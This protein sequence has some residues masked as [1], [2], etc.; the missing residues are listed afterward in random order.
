MS[1]APKRYFGGS[2]VH[3][4]A[5]RQLEATTW[6]EFVTRYIC[7]PV[8]FH[9]TCAEFLAHPDRDKLK[10]GEYVVAASFPE[11]TTFRKD[12]NADGVNALIMDIDDPTLARQFFESPDALSEA[13]FPHNF[14]CYTTAKHTPENPRIKIIWDMKTGSPVSCHRAA[15]AMVCDRLGFPSKFSGSRESKTLSL[16]AYRPLQFK[17]EEFKAIVCCRVDGIPIDPADIPEQVLQDADSER[18]YSSGGDAP[19]YGLLYLPIQD[20]TVEDVREALFKLDPDCEYEPWT[21]T[22]M[23][24]KHQFTEPDEAREAYE[25]WNEWSAN[26]TKYSD[27]PTTY[28]KWRSFRP[29]SENRNPITIRTLFHM[30]IKAG[31]SHTKISTI[32]KRTFSEWLAQTDDVDE[33]M[34]GGPER[35]AASPFRNTLVEE[36]MINQLREKI[37]VLSGGSI[38]KA[39]IKKQVQD[40]KFRDK[41]ETNKG[42][43]PSWLGPFTF[44]S[45][46]NV[47]Y[48]I[49]TGDTLSPDSFN[50]TFSRYLMPKEKD[51]ELAKSGKPSILPQ[52]MALNIIQIE[53]VDGITYD[54]REKGKSFFKQDGK[55]YVNQYR[56]STIPVEDEANSD[57]AGRL[58]KKLLDVVIGD[59]EYSRIILDFCAFIV[60][61]PGIKIPWAPLIQGAQGCGKTSI[62]ECVGAAIGFP[63]R[64]IV[65]QGAMNSD[66]NEWR[67]GYQVCAIEELKS[68]GKSKQDMANKLKDAIT[69]STVSINQKF[70]DARCAPNVTNYF[71]FTNNHDAMYMEDSDRR[72][73]VVESPLQH[74][75]Q[76][77]AVTETGFFTELYAM[78]QE[79]AGAFRHFFLNHVISEDFPKNGPAPITRFR[80]SAIVEGKNP[81]QEAVEDLIDSDDLLIGSDVI[82]SK[83]LNDLTDRLIQ[84]NGKVSKYLKILG[85]QLYEDGQR[86]LIGG[87]RTTIWVHR[88]NYDVNGVLAEELLKERVGLMGDNL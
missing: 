16:P 63:N 58:F 87:E 62:A 80:K 8:S 68:P 48:N 59:T 10:D 76:V 64:F 66:F 25:M 50:N 4:G 40:T 12:S 77:V 51:S 84:R 83:R 46:Q 32:V 74:K 73:F 42:N 36:A 30:A 6:R 35:I 70:K 37:K 39:T 55:T 67:A 41:T 22:A 9:M 61:R 45:P 65:S 54:P 21:H 56:A 34:N 29:Y 71:L 86:F 19:D 60:Q 88:Q 14:V 23:A 26:G 43:I 17:D 79:H 28:A 49:A 11:G 2:S 15:V 33:L 27:E 85:Y 47:F 7:N 52:H 24:L 72:Y 5:I 20:I 13:C 82:H 53:V 44:I 69:N 75:H 1:D 81:L 18:Q 3:G 31:W 38:D 78:V 57:E